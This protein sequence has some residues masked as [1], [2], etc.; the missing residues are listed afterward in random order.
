MPD[1]SRLPFTSDEYRER[2]R[3]VREEMKARDIEL[4]YVTSPPNIQYLT[5]YEAI[6]YPNRLPVGVLL[7]VARDDTLFFDWVRHAP[8]VGTSVFCDE[9]RYFQYGESDAVV[10]AAIAERGRADARI[11]L[12]AFSLNPSAPVM[13]AL[14]EALRRQGATVIS[15]DWVVDK[16]RLYKSPTEVERVRRAA[17]IADRAMLRLREQLRPG[18]TEAEVS[19]RLNLLLAE[20]GSEPAA[21]LPLVNSGPTAW[22]D[23]HAFPSQR[24][25]QAGDVVSVDCCAVVDRYH[26]NLQR[27]FVL[28]PSATKARAMIAAAAGSIEVLCR[29]ARLGEG[30]ERAAAAAVA[31]V[32]ERIPAEN[33]WW[34]GGYALGLGTP[35]SWVGH[36]YLANDGEER[37]ELREGYVSNYENVFFD[38]AEGFE[39]GY[40]D[41]VVMTSDG[42]RALSTI[43]RE[44]LEVPLR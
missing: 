41:T 20:E 22:V 36:T 10:S 28:G 26:A 38:E 13:T 27:T 2:Q 35:P 7:D 17:A 21:T 12:E 19:A 34:V 29:E 11:A 5:G 33:I 4:L 15:G 23:V 14:G 42:L 31:Y 30:P 9:A 37:C 24:C 8:Y 25:L 44:L 40:I 16:L 1:F 43:P 3:R 6:W 39:A 32:R 18:L